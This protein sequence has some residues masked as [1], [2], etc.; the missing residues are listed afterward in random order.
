MDTEWLP[1]GPEVQ[2]GWLYADGEFVSPGSEPEPEP[3][4]PAGAVFSRTYTLNSDVTTEPGLLYPSTSYIK[5]NRE[6][7]LLWQENVEEGVDILCELLPE[8][9]YPGYRRRYFN[10]YYYVPESGASKLKFY[11]G[12][13]GACPAY[14]DKS[15]TLTAYPAGQIPDDETLD[16]ASAKAAAVESNP[17]RSTKK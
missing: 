12:Y 14:S 9:G 15:Y 1:C 16:A 8:D 17:K 10:L 6:D 3:E 7:A 13:D 2:V 4:E 5:L 11:D